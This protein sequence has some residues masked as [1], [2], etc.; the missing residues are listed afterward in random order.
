MDIQESQK[1]WYESGVYL[2]LSSLT[3]FS[4]YMYT[5]LEDGK[6][7]RKE[8]RHNQKMAKEW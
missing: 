4:P 6:K 2:K 5:G 3:S 8:K 1:R 7:R